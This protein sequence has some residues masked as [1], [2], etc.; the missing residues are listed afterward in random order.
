MEKDVVIHAEHL[1]K[2]YRIYDKATDRV[3]E[4]LNPFGKKYS[5]D[6]YAL[7]D[8]DF[9]VRRG[10]TVGIIGRNGSGKSTLLKIITGVLTPT[11]G[12]VIV[13]GKVSA[14]LELG[15]GFNPELS[16]I[17]NVYFNGAINGLSK[18]AVD[19]ALDD[20]LS[21]ADI[22]DF[23]YQPVKTYSSGMFMRLAFAVA[24]HVDPDIFIVDEA[25]SVGDAYFQKKCLK[26]FYHL[27]DKGC[28]I[29][30]VSHETYA[31]RTTCQ[32][33]LYLMNGRKVMFGPSADVVDQYLYDLEVRAALDKTKKS[34]ADKVKQSAEADLDKQYIVT[35]KKVCV[36]NEKREIITELRS[37]DDLYLKFDYKITGQLPTN[38]SFV[39]NLYKHDGLYLCGSTTLMEKIEPLVPKEEGSVIVEFSKISLLAGRYKFRVAINDDGGLGIYAE[40]NPGCEFKVKDQFEAVGLVNLPHEWKF[41]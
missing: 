26:E 17:E 7:N 29:L 11:S 39:F 10:E 22:G 6:F 15:A 12:S 40:A 37:G 2:V 33:A 14:L 28:S 25:L 23:I 5:R 18:E 36:M 19:A 31:V 3:K 16:G 24:I 38:I 4:T 30:F 21:F 20:I 41:L 27:K 34:E 9:E 13:N 32:R 35:I 8:V 1:T